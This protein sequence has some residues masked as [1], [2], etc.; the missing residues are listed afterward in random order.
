MPSAPSVA[1][2]VA[3]HVFLTSRTDGKFELSVSQGIAVMDISMT[4]HLD[5]VRAAERAL[6]EARAIG[7]AKVFVSRAAH[8]RLDNLAA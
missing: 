2:A 3:E 1:T 6:A 5:F 7:R 4:T 8:D